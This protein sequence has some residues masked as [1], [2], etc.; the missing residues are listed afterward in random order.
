[1]GQVLASVFVS[2][3][4]DD[5]DKARAI[6][7]AL[8]KAGHAVWW[9]FHIKGGAEYGREIEQ[10]LEQSDAVV[11]LWSHASVSSAWVRDEAAAGRD[12]G[13]LLP[14]RLD[15]SNPPMGFRQYQNIDLTAWT[16]RGK[17]PKLQD[18]LA[19]IDRLASGQPAPPART[20]APALSRTTI[21]ANARA[22]LIVAL[23]LTA[24]SV[25]LIWRPWNAYSPP[26]VS[27][28]PADQSDS[29]KILASDL[30]IKL[31]SLQ[32][33]D[34]GA[35]RLVEPGSGAKP[36]F[37]LRVGARVVT[38]GAQA[39]LA[40]IDGDGAL[41][42]SREFTQP[43]GNQPDLRQQVAYSTGQVLRCATEA[44]APDHPKL[45]PSVLTVYLKGCADL[46]ATSDTRMSIS[47]FR[48]VTEKAPLFA[49]GWGKLLIAELEAFKATS[50]SDQPLQ[51]NM[52]RHVAEAKKVSPD[53]AE[54]Y[55]V[56]SWLQTPRPI[57]GWMRFADEA[58]KKKPDNAAIL[59]N[60]A[61]GLGHVGRI[62]EALEDARRASEIEPLSPG[63][64]QTLIAF[65]GD[66][67]AHQAA[68]R[69]LNEAERL[70]PGASNILEARFWF[71]YRYGDP[72][73]A[74]AI[75]ESG[76]LSFLPSPAQTSFLRARVNSSPANIALA[77][78]D[79]RN[80]YERDGVPSQLI[81]TLGTFG[82]KDEAIKVLLSANP[83]VAHGIISV[84]FRR[85]A[86][87]EFR[88]DP[89]FM[90]IAR[91]Y[92]LVE[93]WQATG[94]WPDFCFEPDLPYDCKQEGTKLAT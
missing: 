9:D 13:R 43:G 11:V 75:L 26:F 10:A 36:E 89:R 49:G 66:S 24:A 46:S 48:T 42:W 65:L 27:V 63:A 55:L 78:A 83:K 92:G 74:S 57:L 50:A 86:L 90:I 88:R 12:R 62:S 4:R 69:E 47:A 52:R 37:T 34:S 44:L 6:A 68:R 54:I 85:P 84:F 91:R 30:F 58:L 5:S 1:M 31:G 61:T 19:A 2:Y 23:T 39:N 73:K 29:A 94:R 60:R 40:L 67:G 53:L 93:Y 3:A 41:L 17:P 45:D 51:N 70:W 14:V 79:A 21:S 15:E 22:V 80:A 20:A 32:T 56:Q 72:K 8:E 16:G 76:R 35:L 7:L 87:K 18:M 38:E 71:E 81:Q 82:R 64:R 28:E 25:L 33:D 77:I 59:Q